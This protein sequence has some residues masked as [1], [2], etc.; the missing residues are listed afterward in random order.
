MPGPALF[1]TVLLTVMYV[2]MPNC[3][4]G[5]DAR[6]VY[7]PADSTTSEHR[8]AIGPRRSCPHTKAGPSR[9]GSGRPMYPIIP[10]VTDGELSGPVRMD[11]E[12]RRELA[13]E[14]LLNPIIDTPLFVP[15][16]GMLLSMIP[17]NP[18]APAG[19][20]ARVLDREDLGIDLEL[21]LF[22]F[23]QTLVG[24][25]PARKMASVYATVIG[26]VLGTM[27]AVSRGCCSKKNPVPM[28]AWSIDYEK[29]T[30]P[31]VIL[32]TFVNPVEPAVCTCPFGARGRAHLGTDFAAPCRTTVR[33][34]A[35]GRVI[36]AGS[37]PA[38]GA[39]GNI[40]IMDHGGSVFTLYGHVQPDKSLLERRKKKHWPPYEPVSME[41]GAQIGVIASKRK[42]ERSSGPHLHFEILVLLQEKDR[43]RASVHNALTF[44]PLPAETG[45][46]PVWRSGK[47][48]LHSRISRSYQCASLPAHP[49]R[50]ILA[51]L[52]ALH[53]PTTPFNV[54]DPEPNKTRTSDYA[55][56]MPTAAGA[57][58]KA[59]KGEHPALPEISTYLRQNGGR[60][61][62]RED[63]MMRLGIMPGRERARDPFPD[64]E[65]GFNPVEALLTEL[66]GNPFIVSHDPEGASIR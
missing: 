10:P 4:S 30:D 58:L 7:C 54:T 48:C 29:S 19:A 31:A 62:G 3:L 16:P 56:R 38:F 39:F 8:P 23:D 43:V 60:F 61:F 15:Q 25:S 12:P 66:A 55:L 20:A 53:Y 49:L 26:E 32:S 34:A 11:R 64:V 21:R 63:L 46:F 1:L 42:G 2:G 41:R 52:R 40:I 14:A 47:P 59:M 28:P 6:G 57:V 33:A 9:D 65:I 36:Y 45:L 18:T 24:L 50:G 35:A 27:A 22:S 44:L 17:G 37:L 13:P 5:N 51:V